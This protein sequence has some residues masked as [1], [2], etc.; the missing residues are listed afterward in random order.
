MFL[1][2]AW[3]PNK[4]S[5]PTAN[6]PHLPPIHTHKLA[7]HPFKMKTEVFTKCVTEMSER[8]V[9]R[10]NNIAKEGDDYQLD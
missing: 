5:T 2:F 1:Y 6:I 8:V 3:Y 4:V 7:H 9:A 10:K